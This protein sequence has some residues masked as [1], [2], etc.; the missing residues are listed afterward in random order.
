MVLLETCLH[1]Q[2]PTLDGHQGW[3]FF[4][5]DFFVI[6]DSTEKRPS[7]CCNTVRVHAKPR[8]RTTTSETPP[9]PRVGDKVTIPRSKSVL[10]INHVHY[11]GDE[12]DLQLP[13]TNLQWFRV[14]TDRLTF[15]ERKPPARTS[16]PFTN[17]EPV[18]DAEE[19]LERIAAVQRENLERSD[20]DIDILKS[21]LKTQRVPRAAIEALEGLTVE[22]HVSWKK[23]VKEIE[24]LLEE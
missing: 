2:I 15:V 7:A 8:K 3:D 12:V 20:G 14:R 13:G 5:I 24:E 22:Q 4:V 6:K 11:G 18:F 21:Y 23:A 17:P 16:N 19:V 9:M 1:N 10:E